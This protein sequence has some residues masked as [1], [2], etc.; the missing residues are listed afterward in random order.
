MPWCEPCG[1]YLT[2]NSVEFDGTCPTC[3][4]QVEPAPGSDHTAPGSVAVP[5]SVAAPT[6]RKVPW[7]FWVILVLTSL[8]LLWRA[9][10]GLAL[11]F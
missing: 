7:H 10:Q 2:P 4:N 6:V 1:R 3:G 8:Y 5:E 9:Y 11:L